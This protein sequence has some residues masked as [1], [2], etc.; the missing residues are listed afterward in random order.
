MRLDHQGQRI[1]HRRIPS[2]EVLPLFRD[3]ERT[4]AVVSHHFKVSPSVAD[5]VVTQLLSEGLIE[6]SRAR[7]G[8]FR[9]TFTGQERLGVS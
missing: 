2:S 9:L 4:R 1:T 8:W 6:E 5:G 3:G 7:R